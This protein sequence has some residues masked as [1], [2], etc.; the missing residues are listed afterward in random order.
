MTTSEGKK[1][2][3]RTVLKYSSDW[4]SFTATTE[5]SPDNGKTW[6]LWYKD[7]GR[8]VKTTTDEQE[9]G[10]KSGSRLGIWEQ[11]SYKYGR[12]KEFSDSPK[13]RR[14]IKMITDSLSIRAKIC[15]EKM[16]IF[17]SPLEGY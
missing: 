9:S 2:L 10:A 14:R 4:N 15:G 7:E 3:L 8:K 17:R 16:P 13:S 12:M 11:V 1:V 5:A 6:K